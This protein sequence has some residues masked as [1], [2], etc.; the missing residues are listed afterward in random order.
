[1]DAFVKIIAAAAKAPLDAQQLA[2]LNAANSTG[3]DALLGVVYTHVSNGE[4]RAQFE[5]GRDHLQPFG[6][7]HGGVYCAVGESLGSLAGAIAS[8]G[9]QVVGVNN[10]TDFLRPGRPGLIAASASAVHLGSSTQL[11]EIEF[12]QAGALLARTSL[13]TMVLR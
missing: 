5:A 9:A 12:T 4:V 1:M 10:S 11:W 8:G 2:E 3:P 13:R 7:V 6:L